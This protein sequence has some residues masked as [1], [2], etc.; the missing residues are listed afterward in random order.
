M[1]GFSRLFSDGAGIGNQMF[2]YAALKG[3]SAFKGYDCCI[4]RGTPLLQAF[5]LPTPVE[6][7]FG[8]PYLEPSF[9]YSE[10]FVGNC[11]DNAN[12]YGYFQTEKYFK[13][14]EQEIRTEFTF[15]PDRKAYCQSQLKNTKTICLHIRRTDYLAYPNHHP[16]CSMDYYTKALAALDKTL[17]VLV[18]SDDP[19][20]CIQHP[21]FQEERFTFV[22]A[23]TNN[24][25]GTG[26][27][28]DVSQN[29]LIIVP[30]AFYNLCLMSMCTHF[31]CANSS[32]SWW[33]AWLSQSENVLVPSQWFGPALAH[34]DTRDLIP[35]RWGS[36]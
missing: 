21:L 2:R 29:N 20:W 14:I 8:I 16:I 30:D 11:P 26:F 15:S 13:H 36:I 3:I 1:L 35:E 31:I 5:T 27:L 10:D 32:Y 9:N 12:L 4:P 22:G 34:Y 28:K 6:D 24:H 7:L 19:L 23:K 17:P 18:F 25:R 33:A